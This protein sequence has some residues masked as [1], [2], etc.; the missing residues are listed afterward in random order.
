MLGTVYVFFKNVLKF[1]VQLRVENFEFWIRIFADL[2]LGQL[3]S[4]NG[5]G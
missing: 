3:F 4:T 2:Q 1:D 5:L